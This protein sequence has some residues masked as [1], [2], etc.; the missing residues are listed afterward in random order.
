[1]TFF[2]NFIS[3]QRSSGLSFRAW[4]V[5]YPVT[6]AGCRREG[7]KSKCGWNTLY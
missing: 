3:G 2:Y 5:R 1:V 4:S 7:D 6:G